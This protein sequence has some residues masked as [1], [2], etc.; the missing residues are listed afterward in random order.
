M[1]SSW[2]PYMPP[3]KFRTDGPSLRATKPIRGFNWENYDG[4]EIRVEKSVWRSHIDEP[5]RPKSKGAILLITQAIWRSRPAACT[6]SYGLMASARTSSSMRMARGRKFSNVRMVRGTEHP[7][8][9]VLP[10]TRTN[11]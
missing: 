1:S 4:S 7:T 2:G 9:N 11:H 10:L 3:P 5:K 8:C 6:R